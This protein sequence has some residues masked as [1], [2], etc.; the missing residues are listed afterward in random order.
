[1][2]S[3]SGERLP[4]NMVPFPASGRLLIGQPSSGPSASASATVTRDTQSD[5]SK[6][7][8]L[9]LS[10]AVGLSTNP[11]CGLELDLFGIENDCQIYP[12]GTQEAYYVPEQ[13]QVGFA[14]GQYFTGSFQ[15]VWKRN[16]G[17]TLKT[18]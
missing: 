18:R 17:I 9:I 13:Y 5:P 7:L 8:G 11:H 14:G 4:R 15:K 3:K 16:P 1:M 6:M 2:P 10:G 12:I